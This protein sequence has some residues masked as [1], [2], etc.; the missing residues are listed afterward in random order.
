[1]RTLVLLMAAASL[2]TALAAQVPGP[3]LAFD[4]A[5]IKPGESSREGGRM[6]LMP[7]GGILADLPLRFFISIAHDLRPFQLDAPDWVSSVSYAVS[8]KPAGTA[9]RDETFAMLRTLLEDRCKLTF[10]RETRQT[11]GF[12]LVRVR[13]DTLGPDLK[14]S[15]VN[16]ETTPREPA[17]RNGE[18]T[19]TSWRTNGA[20]IATISRWL[21]DEVD[22][23]VID[24]T[25]LTG[26]FDVRL[27]WSKELA[28][29]GDAP[30]IFTAVQEQLGLRLERRRVPAEMFVVDHIE[31]P[32]P[33]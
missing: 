19:A 2:T 20:P 7:D 14:P 23:P 8:A 17:C 12:A 1:M 11:S 25:G 33:D 6:R 32:T 21:V 13:P 28:P 10:H 18:F 27:R 24:E 30:S 22:G 29:T 5:S 16:C 31:R 4:V 26:T 9:T 3:R 15:S